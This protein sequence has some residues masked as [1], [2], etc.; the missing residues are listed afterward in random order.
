MSLYLGQAGG[1]LFDSFDQSVRHPV[2]ASN[3]GDDID[4]WFSG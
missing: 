2:P 4:E 1:D 3:D